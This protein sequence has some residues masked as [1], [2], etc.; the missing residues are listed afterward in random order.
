MRIISIDVGIKNLA[1]C[2]MEKSGVNDATHVENYTILQW[3]V[4]NLCGEEHVC[5][6][7]LQPKGKKKTTAPFFSIPILC[8]K[9]ATFVKAVNGI[10][11]YYCQIHAKQSAYLLP[12]STNTLKNIKKMKLADVQTYA[13][14]HQITYPANSKK[15][16]VIKHIETFLKSKVLER[17]SKENA[18]DMTLVQMGVKLVDEFDKRLQALVGTDTQALAGTQALAIQHIDHI[19]IENQISPIAN[20]MK[21][22]QGM[23]AQYFIMRG[24]AKISFIS[25][26]NK[27]KIFG[28]TINKPQVNAVVEDTDTLDATDTLEDTDTL[29][30]TNKYSDRKKLG[31]SIVKE[32]L[33]KDVIKHKHWCQLFS[34]H[35][36]KD[37]L[38]DAFLQGCWFLSQ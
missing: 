8:N 24:Q 14:S 26:M 15:D 6:C 23:I 18:N 35:K 21:T 37:D 10:E 33:A 36:K 28:K 4:I 11:Q 9:K 7:P 29:E 13:T 32:I 20:R 3:D 22:L 38:A 5:N 1:Y 34:T 30:T 16:V 31:V 17:I 27:L 2:V 19:V 25:A 12:T